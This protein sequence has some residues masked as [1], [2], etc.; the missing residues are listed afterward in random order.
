MLS[1]KAEGVAKLDGDER[2]VRGAV[3]PVLVIV[4]IEFLEK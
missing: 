2:D 4:D 1:F 3:D